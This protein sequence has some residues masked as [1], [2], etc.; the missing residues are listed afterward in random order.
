MDSR[1]TTRKLHVRR[2]HSSVTYLR[3][4]SV[5]NGGVLKCLS[6]AFNR[7]RHDATNKPSFKGKAKVKVDVYLYSA[8]S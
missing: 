8:L 1:Q 4:L 6:G 7:L 3:P 5:Y 2:T